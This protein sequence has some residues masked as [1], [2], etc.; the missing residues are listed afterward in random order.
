MDKLKNREKETTYWA[1]YY[2]VFESMKKGLTMAEASIKF[3]GEKLEA[4]QYFN[5]YLKTTVHQ[6]SN[7]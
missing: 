2:H 3:V 6:L 4:A 7:P 5:T 1:L